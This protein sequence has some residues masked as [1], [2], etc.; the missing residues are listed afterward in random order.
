MACEAEGFSDKLLRARRYPW[1]GNVRLD[2]KGA[3]V[4]PASCRRRAQSK[5][6]AERES[7]RSTE[8]MSGFPLTALARSRE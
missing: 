3:R 5:R 8:L 7:S 2:W 4:I 6:S 1:G